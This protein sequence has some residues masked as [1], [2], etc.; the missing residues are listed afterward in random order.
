MTATDTAVADTTVATETAAGNGHLP[1][2]GTSNQIE[3]WKPPTDQLKGY[4]D[5]TILD[6][7]GVPPSNIIKDSTPWAL[8]FDLW[9][10]GDTWKCVSGTLCYDVYFERANDGFRT[11]LSE[12]LK[13]EIR[14]GFKGCEHFTNHRVHVHKTVQI[15][16]GALPPGEK[17]PGLYDWRAVL[18]YLDPCEQPGVLSGY[19]KG[20]VQVWDH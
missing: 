19:D 16:A 17:K 7:H 3:I 5:V 12:V 6:D 8:R 1:D 20:C 18:S 13:T 15:P 9:L 10:E 4:F 14:Q 11:S 2:P